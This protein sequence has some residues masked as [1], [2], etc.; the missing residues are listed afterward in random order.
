MDK[1]KRQ[2]EV[3]SK[4]GTC[5]FV[6]YM[7]MNNAYYVSLAWLWSMDNRGVS[8]YT[9]NGEAYLVGA[10]SGGAFWDGLH[11]RSNLLW[12]GKRYSIILV[13]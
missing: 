4:N 6:R 7:P 8:V 11:L 1:T 5:L 10:V 12:Q 3:H 13:G 2:G 9:M